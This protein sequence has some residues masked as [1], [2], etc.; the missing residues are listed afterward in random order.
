MIGAMIIF[1]MFVYIR[2]MTPRFSTRDIEIM[3]ATWKDDAVVRALTTG[4]GN[5][6]EL[7]LEPDR[8]HMYLSPDYIKHL[9]HVVDYG[10]LCEALI[11][12]Q[13]KLDDEER[14]RCLAAAFLKF[15][16]ETLQAGIATVVQARRYAEELSVKDRLRSTIVHSAHSGTLLLALVCSHSPPTHPPNASPYLF[17]FP[18]SPPSLV[19]T[20]RSHTSLWWRVASARSRTRRPST[21]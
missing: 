1:G 4:E 12:A 16:G 10:P 14:A 17:R 6:S 13:E 5:I 9:C 2:T 15:P 8:L 20:S 18:H 11:D 21:K 7:L 3:Q 19:Q